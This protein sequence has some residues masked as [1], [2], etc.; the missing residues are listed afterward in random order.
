[1][2]KLEN[3][4][5]IVD[6][7]L[8]KL[9]MSQESKLRLKNE[10]KK[11]KNLDFKRLGIISVP[12]VAAAFAFIFFF[13][14]IFTN[15]GIVKVLAYD[16][17]KEI[18]PRKV[19]TVEL[20]E[21]FL[22]STADFSIDLFKQSYTKGENSLVSPTSV[23]LALGMTANGAAGNTLKEFETLLG[24]Y[25]LNIGHLNSYYNSLARKLATV[26]S[27]KVSIANS[28]WYRNDERLDVKTDFLQANADYYNAA[29]YKA[30]FDSEQ[31]V[32]DI[33]GWVKNNTGNLI[34]KIIDKINPNTIMY[35]INA[36]YFEDKWEKSYAK[37]QVRKGS[38]QL[39]DG[40][41]KSV[42]FMYS[43]EEGYLKDSN[44][45]GFIK[46]YK[47]GKYSFVALLPN[48]GVSIDSYVASLSGESFINLLKNKS[49]DKVSA[50]LPK[51]KSEYTIKLVEP[52]KKLGLEECFSDTKANFTKMATSKEGAI[53]IGD[54]LHK[55]FITVDDEGT[56][57]GAVTKVEMQ[58]KSVQLTHMITLNRPFVYAIIDNETKLPLFMGTMMNPEF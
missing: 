48:E 38:F 43:E 21:Q 13:T 55:T 52:L 8:D 53:F 2:K 37:E 9:D 22:R 30:D 36:V 29:A 41:K 33:N 1:M 6:S 7:N 47:N 12:A 25:N 18:T 31:T 27:G 44:A 56:K 40:T 51:F 20:S 15:G 24:K 28:I 42:D 35:L 32:K 34:D 11:T 3:F 26:E 45:Q 58:V 39:A 50:A 54:V 23:Y 57:A 10:V 16:L 19:E 46:P 49:R 14:G 5:A 4:K 17:M